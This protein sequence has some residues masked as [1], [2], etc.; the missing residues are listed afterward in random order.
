MEELKQVFERTFEMM[1]SP[2]FSNLWLILVSLAILSA[3]I[4]ALMRSFMRAVH[5]VHN[6]R[7]AADVPVSDSSP[8]PQQTGCGFVCSDSSCTWFN[9]PAGVKWCEGCNRRGLCSFC[10]ADCSMRSK[11]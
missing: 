5:P 10:S 3:L 8:D 6:M 11:K 1:K 4:R 9:N 2:W 7:N